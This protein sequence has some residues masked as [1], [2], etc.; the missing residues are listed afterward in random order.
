MAEASSAKLEPL[1]LL[2]RSQKGAAAAKIAADATS[3]VSMN[4]SNTPSPYGARMVKA[5]PVA[6][7]VCLWRAT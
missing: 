2:A 3:K 5:D 1:I 7:C 6:W 4:E